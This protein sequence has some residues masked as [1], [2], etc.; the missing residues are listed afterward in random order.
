MVSYTKL[1]DRFVADT[2]FGGSGAAPALGRAL[3]RIGWLSVRE[4]TPDELASYLVDLVHDC[5]HSHRDVLT[6]T[7][8]IAE[9][10]RDAGPMLDGG[11]PPIEAYEPAAEELLERYVTDDGSDHHPPVSLDAL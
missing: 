2:G 1:R 11:L 4:P 6:L 10:L 7:R 8:A 5:V 9:V 3:V